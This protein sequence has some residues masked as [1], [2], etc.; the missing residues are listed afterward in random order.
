MLCPPPPHTPT[1]ELQHNNILQVLIENDILN[2]LGQLVARNYPKNIKK[3]ACLI[4]SNIAAGSKDQIQVAYSTSLCVSYVKMLCHQRGVP[5]YVL[6]LTCCTIMLLPCLLNHVP[7]ISLLL[8]L[9]SS[10][11]L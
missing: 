6:L 7:I 5:K 4:V 9:D 2:C 3:Q 1:F 11:R 10:N 8:A